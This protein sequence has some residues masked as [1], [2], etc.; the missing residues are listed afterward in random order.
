VTTLTIIVLESV[1]ASLRGE[2]ARWMIEINAGVFVGRI[3]AVVRDKIWHKVIQRKG[4]GKA[5][6]VH[7]IDNEQRFCIEMNGF[8][9]RSVVDYD[10]MQLVH[11]ANRNAMMGEIIDGTIQDPPVDRAFPIS[12]KKLFLDDGDASVSIYNTIDEKRVQHGGNIATNVDGTSYTTPVA[13]PPGFV[14]RSI[15]ASTREGNVTIDI[16]AESNARDHPKERAWQPKWMDDMTNAC[17]SIMNDAISPAIDK[18]F[19]GTRVACV[20]IETTNYLPKAFQGFVNIICIAII[21]FHGISPT[22]HVHQAFNTTRDRD[23]VP[24]LVD[25]AL[26]HADNIDT[27]LVF[28]KNFDI[29]ILQSLIDQHGINRELPRNIIDLMERFRSLEMLEKELFRLNGFKRV[30]TQKGKYDEY[31]QIFKGNGSNAGNIEPIGSYNMI[32]ALT[33]LMYYLLIHDFTFLH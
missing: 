7:A 27:L 28:N 30:Q 4:D 32:D 8:R 23:L 15:M 19:H 5:I 14:E 11:V 31:Y 2:L 6:L 29:K 16:S 20:D 25:R 21:D 10:G 33:P 18:H 22:L 12:R 26:Q 1:P 13:L 9:E 3:S 17:K 24:R